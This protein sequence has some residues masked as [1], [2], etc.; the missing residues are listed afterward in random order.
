MFKCTND[1]FTWLRSLKVQ[2]KDEKQ[3]FVFEGMN[4]TGLFSHSGRSVS[5]WNLFYLTWNVVLLST[6]MVGKK[7][8]EDA[9]TLMNF[10]EYC[11]YFRVIDTSEA[12]SLIVEQLW[13]ELLRISEVISKWGL[14]SIQRVLLLLLG[15]NSCTVCM[16]PPG[17]AAAG[18]AGEGGAFPEEIRKL[19]YGIIQ[20]LFLCD[21]L[22]SSS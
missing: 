8:K 21:S 9:F 15:H 1:A 3:V 12:S 17:G 2:S 18:P 14:V 4:A 5:Q 6:W 20:K 16:H 11:G 7:T 22:V 10:Y 13:G 19:K